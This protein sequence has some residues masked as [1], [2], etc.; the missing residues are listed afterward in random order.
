MQAEEVRA[1]GYDNVKIRETYDNVV[2]GVK[3]LLKE[4]SYDVRR[5][6][7]DIRADPVALQK[8]GLPW[9][10]KAG[11]NEEESSGEDW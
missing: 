2:G 11:D 7:T 9:A 4:F 1:Q 3:E 10:M 5:P 8:S 6:K